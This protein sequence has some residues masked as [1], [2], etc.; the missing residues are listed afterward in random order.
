M[1]PLARSR[2]STAM[3]TIGDHGT[4]KLTGGAV[5]ITLTAAE[6]SEAQR[7]LMGSN[8]ALSVKLGNAGPNVPIPVEMD[9]VD[10]ILKALGR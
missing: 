3:I 2:P 6:L 5:D 10:E 9:E 7:K 1:L 4:L 8:Q